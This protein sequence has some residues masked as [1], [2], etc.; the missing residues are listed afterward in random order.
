[1][2]YILTISAFYLLPEVER[3]REKKHHKTMG[4]HAVTRGLVPPPPLFLKNEQ[5]D[6]KLHMDP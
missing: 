3:E 1:M 6:L 2:K 4:L 5:G